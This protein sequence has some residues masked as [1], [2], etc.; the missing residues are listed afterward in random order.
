MASSVKALFSRLRGKPRQAVPD[1]TMPAHRLAALRS[2]ALD[3]E[4]PDAEIGRESAPDLQAT[5]LR[6]DD[7]ASFAGPRPI[8]LVRRPRGPDDDWSHATSWFGGLPK[9]GDAP[10][11]RGEDGTRLPFA[12]QVHL[13]EVA[14]LRPEAALPSSGSLAFFL[15]DGAVIHVPAGAAAFTPA[16]ADLPPA[17]EEGGYPFQEPSLLSRPVFPFWPVDFLPIDL[18]DELRD[19]RNVDRHEAIEA[20]VHD[21]VTARIP[22]RDVALGATSLSERLGGVTLP[23]WWHGVDHVIAT[24]R[25]ELSTAPA[26][27]QSH[28]ASR[29]QA[30]DKLASADMAADA[31]PEE[32]SAAQASLTRLED[33]IRR[34]DA[35]LA[36]LPAMVQALEGFAAE[37]DRWTPLTDEERSVLVDALATVSRQFREIVPSATAFD[38]GALSVLSLRAMMTGDVAAFAAIPEPIR[39]AINDHYRLPPQGLQQMFGLGLN[40][41]TAAYDH[42]GDVLLLQLVYD[43]MMEWRFGDMGAFQFWI[44]PEDLAARHW[45]RVTI[46]FECD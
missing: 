44:A 39:E 34:F 12:A 5:D 31:S 4:L 38:I 20:A 32:V 11:P 29:D 10:W 19:Y 30:H 40:I 35:Q 46:T 9:L 21:A 33:L 22:R 27:R 15:G 24:L 3:G 41:Q 37:R 8:V 28:V 17:Y 2:R 42:E 13:A 6:T 26:R 25:Q 45:D 23:V 43:D 18:P 1:L 7:G 16:P 14:P 36:G